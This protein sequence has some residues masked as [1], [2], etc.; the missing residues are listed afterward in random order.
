MGKSV[1]PGGPAGDERPRPHDLFIESGPSLSRQE[2][3]VIFSRCLTAFRAKLG[4]RCLRWL[5]WSQRRRPSARRRRQARPAIVPPCNR[6]R[7]ACMRWPRERRRQRSMGRRAIMFRRASAT[8]LAAWPSISPRFQGRH[9]RLPGRNTWRCQLLFAG[10]AF[11]SGPLYLL[12]S[13]AS[14]DGLL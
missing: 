5:C 14:E 10:T 1:K 6:C 2:P 13:R 9:L 11:R 3:G 12:P 4:R 7:W 8:S